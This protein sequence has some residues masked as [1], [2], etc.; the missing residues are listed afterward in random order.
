MYPVRSHRALTPGEEVSTQQAVE[1][2]Q[3]HDIHY[4]HGEEKV[5]TVIQP[6]V[7]VHDV[8]GEVEL[9]A[10]AKCDVG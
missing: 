9:C 6:G 7:I 1:I 4:Y 2:D 10:Q 8:P 3:D 5:S